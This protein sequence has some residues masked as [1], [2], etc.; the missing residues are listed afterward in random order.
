MPFINETVRVGNSTARIKNYYANG[1][2][3]LYDIRGDIQDGSIISCDESGEVIVLNNFSIE[4]KYD[5]QYEDRGNYDELIVTDVGGYIGLDTH[6][7]GNPSQEYQITY[8][9]KE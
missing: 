2:V 5:L 9:V 7:N 1:M 6:F 4:D 8:L 3:V